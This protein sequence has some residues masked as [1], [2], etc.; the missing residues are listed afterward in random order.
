MGGSH[1]DILR[2]QRK[3]QVVREFFNCSLRQESRRIR[4]KASNGTA[5]TASSTTMNEPRPPLHPSS[6]RTLSSPLHFSSSSF[7]ATDTDTD[8]EHGAPAAIPNG[9]KGHKKSVSFSSLEIREYKVVIGDHPCC[10]RGVPLSLGWDY[11]EGGTLD[12]DAYEEGRSPRRSR[13]DLR[14]SSEERSEILTDVASQEDLRRA[15]RKLHRVRSCS[16]RLCERM[17]ARFFDGPDPTVPSG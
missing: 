2:K 14:T 1:A 16:A 8:D 5:T 15:Q 9:L 7:H 11:C 4:N 17:N 10:T 3:P 12:L 6:D 13:V